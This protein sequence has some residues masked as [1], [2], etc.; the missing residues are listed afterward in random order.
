MRLHLPKTLLAAVL[1]ACAALPTWADTQYGWKNNTPAKTGDIGDLEIITYSSGGTVGDDGVGVETV[2]EVSGQNVS[3]YSLTTPTA[4]SAYEYTSAQNITAISASGKDVKITATANQKEFL[5]GDESENPVASVGNSLWITGSKRFD[6]GTGYLANFNG[7]SN[8]YITDAQLYAAMNSNVTL[9]SNYFLGGGITDASVNGTLRLDGTGTIT[10]GKAVTLVG[11][12]SVSRGANNGKVV[13]NGLK[14]EGHSFSIN[15]SQKVEA[16]DVIG[17]GNVSLS[18]TSALSLSG[19]NTIGTLSLNSTATN[20]FTLSSGTTTVST[21]SGTSSILLNGGTL[22]LKAGE[23]ITLSNVKFAG[24]ILDL[25]SSTGSVT[26]TSGAWSGSAG[27]YDVEVVRARTAAIAETLADAIKASHGLN[28]TFSVRDASDYSSVYRVLRT[29]SL[30]G[31]TA[32]LK[33]ASG[34]RIVVDANYDGKTFTDVGLN[35]LLAGDTVTINGLTGWIGDGNSNSILANLVFEGENSINNGSTDG[36]IN[37]SGAIS[38]SGILS[39][40]WIVTESNGTST[41]KT[42]TYVFT[43]DLSGFT[44]KIKDEATLNVTIGGTLADGVSN[45]VKATIDIAGN[46][47]VN[48]EATFT[49]G[50]TANQLKGSQKIVFDGAQTINCTQDGDFSGKID[51]KSGKLT[52]AGSVKTSG[53]LDLCG[54]S[55]TNRYSGTVEVASQGSLTV[56]GTIWGLV[57]SA[58]I[59]L[60]EGGSLKWNDLVITGKTAIADVETGLTIG[61]TAA[62]NTEQSSNTLRN[63]TITYTGTDSKTLSW[64]LTDTDLVV[65]SG[66]LRLGANVN[67]SNVTVSNGSTLELVSGWQQKLSSSNTTWESGATLRYVSTNAVDLD[68]GTVSGSTIEMNCVKGTLNAANAES[69]VVVEGDIKLTGSDA[70][71]AAEF[72]RIVGKSYTFKGGVAG[73]GNLNLNQAGKTTALIFEGDLSG[74]TSQS[75]DW[76]GLYANAGI[77][78]ATI[79]GTPANQEVKN[80]FNK[81]SSGTLNLTIDRDA[82]LTNKVNITSL[83]VN[84][85]KTLSLSEDNNAVAVGS[86]TVGNKAKLV[87]GNKSEG[88]SI[89][90]GTVSGSGTISSERTAA[91][92]VTLGTGTDNA[93]TGTLEA[94][95]GQLNVTAKT[96]QTLAGLTAN[97]G[98]IDVMNATSLSVTDMVIGDNATVGVYSGPDTT[99]ESSLNIYGSE[100]SKASLTIG[101]DATLKANLSVA[102]AKLTFNGGPLAMGSTLTLFADGNSVLSGIDFTTV[103][104]TGLTLFKGVDGFS[105]SWDSASTDAVTI[106]DASTIFGNLDTGAYSLRYTGG[107]NGDVLLIANNPTPEPTT[108]TLSLLALMGL[109]ARRRRKA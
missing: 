50:F 79:S 93:F 70:A 14:T 94:T 51:V 26:I 6:N 12:A 63:S 100:N 77:I 75:T 39:F 16:S 91:Q 17:G 23:D 18:A 22:A 66:T 30:T 9:S 13:F 27:A 3:F 84:D 48:R 108:A 46:L 73:G 11:D 102:Y 98:N 80:A 92:S 41:I 81:D 99:T 101:S 1:A 105:T 104:A 76:S 90:L 2:K 60:Q 87:I 67:A 106:D 62:L 7:F 86:T 78:N 32:K 52:V 68:V 89:N 74:W 65:Q 59:L 82:V 15:G 96:V 42:N 71:A 28:D 57:N 31:L 56:G 35:E 5:R 21:V 33:E 103:T 36:T 24:G 88:T 85:K 109:A 44:G 45:E 95:A 61:A 10:F 55:E 72:T 4:G 58:K 38:G 25:T 54:P 19:D 69:E 97:G 64:T 34:T 20:A 107:T 49:R 37:Y 53:Q 43:G 8:V 83:V 40:D 29:E 47:T